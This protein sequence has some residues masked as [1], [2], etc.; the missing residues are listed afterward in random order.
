LLLATIAVSFGVYVAALRLLGHPAARAL[1]Q[2]PRKVLRRL[3]PPRGD[4]T[5]GRPDAGNGRS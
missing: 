2:L 4:E 5:P 1:A 3:R